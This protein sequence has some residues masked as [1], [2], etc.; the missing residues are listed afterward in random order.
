MWSD[1]QGILGMS[2]EI[3]VYCKL[4]IDLLFFYF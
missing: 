1:K 3:F 2:V 4:Y